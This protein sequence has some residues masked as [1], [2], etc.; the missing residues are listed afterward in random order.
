MVSSG[1][2][3]SGEVS[4]GT[5]SRSDDVSCPWGEVKPS[6][7]SH[8]SGSTSEGDPF[9]VDEPLSGPHTIDCHSSP[10]ELS[11]SGSVDVLAVDGS[12]GNRD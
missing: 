9:S 10:S 3:S 5:S 7:S 4:L 8:A 11:S 2:V 12:S 6:S 1:E